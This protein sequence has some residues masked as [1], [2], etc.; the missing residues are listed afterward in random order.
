MPLD[1]LIPVLQTAIGPV[2]LISGVGMLLLTMTNRLGRTIDRSRALIVLRSA[3]SNSRRLAVEL[4]L[5]ILW[6]RARLLRQAITLATV[7]ALLAA[8]L[9]IVLFMGTLVDLHVTVVVILLFTACLTSLIGSLLFFLRD[10]NL[11]LRALTHE[12][13]QGVE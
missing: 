6:K 11:S 12:L 9:I 4:Q 2:I 1:E 8:F 7:A 10:I 5:G 13:E 3:S